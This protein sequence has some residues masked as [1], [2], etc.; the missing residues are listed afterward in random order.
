MNIMIFMILIRTSGYNPLMPNLHVRNNNIVQWND[1]LVVTVLN[2]VGKID[3]L[4]IAKC[5]R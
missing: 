3:P 5:Y 1:N 2:N 4:V